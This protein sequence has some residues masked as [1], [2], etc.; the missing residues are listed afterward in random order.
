MADDTKLKDADGNPFR[1]L[2]DEV[3]SRNGSPPAQDGVQ[4]QII[5]LATGGD[6]VANDFDLATLATQ[7]TLASILAKIIAAPA[8]E[9]T[10]ASVLASV[11]G[12]ETNTAGLA[13]QT[14][15]AAV[16][17]KLTA[18]PATQ[19]TLAAVLAKITSD[20]STGT[21]QG[22]ANTAL[23]AIQALLTGATPFASAAATSSGQ[24]V[25]GTGR[26][27]SFSARETTT[28][29]GAVLRLRDGSG[30]TILATV[31]LAANESI[32]DSFTNGIAYGTSLYLERVSGTTEVSVATR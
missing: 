19:T 2:T 4:A 31:S 21:G 27:M 14:T 30:G 12:L 32:R 5:K 22:T 18:D 28:S 20:P 26:L 23:A 10:L 9:A 24:L 1:V 15:L 29:A 8:T 11:D 3:T 16:L 17:A 25:A 7:A 6:G 13:S